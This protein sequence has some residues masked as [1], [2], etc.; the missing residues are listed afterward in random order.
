MPFGKPNS[1]PNPNKVFSPIEE[2]V[3][4]FGVNRELDN[5]MPANKN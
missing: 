2:R 1:P 4:A 3:K 5:T